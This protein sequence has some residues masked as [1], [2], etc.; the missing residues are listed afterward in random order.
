MKCDECHDLM[1]AQL[2]GELQAQKQNQLFSH[3]NACAGC[4]DLF[5]D[6][7][8]VQG[9]LANLRDETELSPI[10]PQLATR[11]PPSRLWTR[12][13]STTGR[14]AAA[15]GLLFVGGWLLRS[16]LIESP[17]EH[18]PGVIANVDSESQFEPFVR[19]SPNSAKQFLAVPVESDE[20]RVHIV[21][22]HPVAGRSTHVV[23]PSSAIPTIRR[24]VT[25]DP[26]DSDPID[27]QLARADS[28]TSTTS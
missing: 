17:T 18:D 1:H 24:D 13:F 5:A 23:G 21:W 28:T 27:L 6:Y 12:R 15:I 2:D 7:V 3:L 22:L 26:T 16:T 20:P 8:R 10:H 14:I 9:A 25:P 11:Q 19:L 4:H